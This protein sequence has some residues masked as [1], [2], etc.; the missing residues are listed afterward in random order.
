MKISIIKIAITG[1]ESTGKSMLAE[2]LAKHYQTVWV[3]EYARGYINGLKRPYDQHD[4]LEIAKGQIHSEQDFYPEASK[5]IFCDTELI[6][7]K[8]WSEV[9]FQNCDDWILSKIIENRYDLFLLCNIDLPWEDDPQREHPHER[10]YLFNLYKGELISHG[11]PFFVISGF[12]KERLNNAI[13][14][15]ETFFTF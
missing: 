6:V 5:F 1:P 2:Q 8:I 4:I 3:P 15:I 13:R 14:V 9:K 12:G 10:E 7:T 11:F